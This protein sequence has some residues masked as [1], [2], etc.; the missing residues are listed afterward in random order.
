MLLKAVNG[1]CEAQWH[2]VQQGMFCHARIVC[3]K[4]PQRLWLLI[5]AAHGTCGAMGTRKVKLQNRF[6]N[7]CALVIKPFVSE[8]VNCPFLIFSW[9]MTV[10][11]GGKCEG[12]ELRKCMFA[13]LIT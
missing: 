13:P 10:V 9:L 5:K 8:A 4:V 11:V 2:F 3:A 6:L 1:L 12:F 7:L